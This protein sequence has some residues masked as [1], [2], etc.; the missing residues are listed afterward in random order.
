MLSVKI[1]SKHERTSKKFRICH[2]LLS[3][4]SST[5]MSL[6]SLSQSMLSGA[7]QREW[8]FI[9]VESERRVERLVSVFLSTISSREQLAALFRTLKH[10][11]PALVSNKTKESVCTASIRVPF[12]NA[13]CQ[14]FHPLIL[15]VMVQSPWYFSHFIKT[16]ADKYCSYRPIEYKGSHK[17]QRNGDKPH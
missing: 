15:S 1:S 16:C 12:L 13:L 7:A 3:S 9:L 2:L 6:L 14:V 17:C 5:Q 10:S 8:L 11:F 4:L